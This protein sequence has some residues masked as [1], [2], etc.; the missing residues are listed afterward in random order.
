ML[1]RRSFKAHADIIKL[2]DLVRNLFKPMGT[3]VSR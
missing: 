1:L 2:I 3:T